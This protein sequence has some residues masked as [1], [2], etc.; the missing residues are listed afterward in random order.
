MKNKT[1]ILLI[2]MLGVLSPVGFSFAS[3]D[4]KLLQPAEATTNFESIRVGVAG[5]GGVTFFNGSVLNE[6][7]PYVVADDLRVDGMIWRGPSKGISDGQPL[8][9]AD[10]LM[11]ALTDINDIGMEDY[12]WRNAYLFGDLEVGGNININGNI[13]LDGT[14]DGVNISSQNAVRYSTEDNSTANL[15]V[16][17]SNPGPSK[18]I[19]GIADFE[20]PGVVC[21]VGGWQTKTI[22]IPNNYFSRNN[23]YTV[24]TSRESDTQP[25]LDADM[26]AVLVSRVDRDTFI[27]RWRCDTSGGYLVNWTAIGY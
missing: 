8:K 1:I 17:S 9:I 23:S 24:S 10:T 16:P 14:V 26:T 18:I 19:T 27:I 13:S 12:R 20:I 22:N 4:A 3:D 11:P 6:E 2:I 25:G 7:G 21:F 15:P 5:Q